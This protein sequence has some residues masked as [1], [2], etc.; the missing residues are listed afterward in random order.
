MPQPNI[1]DN[2]LPAF[3]TGGAPQGGEGNE[4]G[5]RNFNRNRGRGRFNNRPRNEGGDNREQNTQPQATESAPAKDP[6]E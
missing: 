5:G 3:I 2:G 4:Q 6:A 1:P